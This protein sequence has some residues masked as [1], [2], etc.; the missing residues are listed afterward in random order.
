MALDHLSRSRVADEWPKDV[1]LDGPKSVVLEEL[2]GELVE[3]T[4]TLP[5][6]DRPLYVDRAEAQ[7]SAEA[8]ANPRASHS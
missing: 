3:P 6:S 5:P 2:L 8:A 1:V 7:S 4:V